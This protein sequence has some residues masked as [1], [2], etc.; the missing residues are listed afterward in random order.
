VNTGGGGG[1]GYQAN[2]NFSGTGGSGIVIIRYAG[3]RQADGGIVTTQG[4]N[5]VH[6]FTGDGTFSNFRYSIN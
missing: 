6:T 4:T 5:T 3:A 1:G 2:P